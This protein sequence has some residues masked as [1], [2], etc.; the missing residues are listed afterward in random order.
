MACRGCHVPV[1]LRSRQ[2]PVMFP[3]FSAIPA[4][5]ASTELLHRESRLTADTYRELAARWP[6]AYSHELEQ[7]LQFVARLEHG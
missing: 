7:L 2:E 1:P 6:D 3:L 4:C 5:L